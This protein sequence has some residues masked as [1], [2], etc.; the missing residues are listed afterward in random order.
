MHPF[1]HLCICPSIHPPYHVSTC[2]PTY[3]LYYPSIH[4]STYLL[5]YS[6][7]YESIHPSIRLPSI[8]SIYHLSLSMYHQSTHPTTHQAYYLDH[9]SST[10]QSSVNPSS[11]S[12][13][14]CYISPARPQVLTQVPQQEGGRGHGLI[15]HT[16]SSL[17][18]SKSQL[19]TM[20]S[21]S[22]GPQRVVPF[23]P[24]HVVL[25]HIADSSPSHLPSSRWGALGYTLC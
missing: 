19:F 12:P 5:P 17:D 9:L 15:F 25:P 13:F 6:S 3:P 8:Y 18:V 7:I 2:V 16:V 21:R 10:Y 23:L 11:I 22:L 14:Q 1:L 4:P 24:H 20:T